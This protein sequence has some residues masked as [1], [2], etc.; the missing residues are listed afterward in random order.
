MFTALRLS[1]LR[2]VADVVPDKVKSEYVTSFILPQILSALI[3]GE[4]TEPVAVT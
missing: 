3:L 1:A 4:L 2:L